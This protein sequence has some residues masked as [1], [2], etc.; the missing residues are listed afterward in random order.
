MQTSPNNPGQH[1][2]LIKKIIG[3]KPGVEPQLRA[4][5]MTGTLSPN[6]NPV[7]ASMNGKRFSDLIRRYQSGTCTPQ[8]KELVE[9]WLENRAESRQADRLSAREREDILA[10][11]STALFDKIQSERKPSV[12]FV[13][14]WR[15][16]AAF[17]LLAVAAY[18]LWFMTYRPAAAGPDVLLASTAAHE[19]RK[20]ILTDG[21]IIWLKGNSSLTYPSEF[22]GAERNITLTGEALFEVAKDPAHP[23]IVSSGDFKTTVLGTS[24]NLKTTPQKVEVLVLTGKVAL[25]AATHPDRIIVMPNQKASLGHADQQPARAE[26][27]PA[28]QQQVV[29][30]TEYIMNFRD[31]RMDEVLQR[32]EKKFNVLTTMD[33]RALANCVITIDLTDQSLDRTLEMVSAILGFTYDIDNSTI[34]IHGEGCEIIN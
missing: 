8:E 23:F 24:F 32:I 10:D 31:T 25:T 22:S 17:T 26:A 19:V 30:H 7:I 3:N 33:D 5:L 12:S 27:K 13:P 28:E 11:V 14:W 1:F 15:I 18:G 16:A 9:K 20:V 34:S 4:L 21:T 6:L 29:D 2:F